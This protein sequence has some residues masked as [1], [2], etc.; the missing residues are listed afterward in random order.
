MAKYS[1]FGESPYDP[2]AEQRE[3]AKYSVGEDF[4][5]GRHIKVKANLH[6]CTLTVH[7][8]NPS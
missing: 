6:R 8:S 3:K 5:D 7:R 1:K 4:G 2:L